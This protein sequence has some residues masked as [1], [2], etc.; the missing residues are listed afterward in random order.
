M[1][2]KHDFSWDITL[3]LGLIINFNLTKKVIVSSSYFF[4][5]FNQTNEPCLCFFTFRLLSKKMGR[6]DGKVIVLSAAAQGIGKA[7]AIVTIYFPSI[8]S[9]LQLYKFAALCFGL[10]TALCDTLMCIINGFTL[11]GLQ[12]LCVSLLN[13]SLSCKGC[14]HGIFESVKCRCRIIGHCNTMVNVKPIL[15]VEHF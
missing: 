1:G 11:R 15:R 12:L 13:K 4:I 2:Y 8:T 9:S 14:Q 6:L 10:L 5:A 3:P 7:S